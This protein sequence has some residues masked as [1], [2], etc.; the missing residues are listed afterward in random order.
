[1]CYC[2]WVV[3]GRGRGCKGVQAF[4]DRKK[5]KGGE[6]GGAGRPRTGEAPNWGCNAWAPLFSVL[7]AVSGGRVH[8]KEESPWSHYGK[9]DK[10]KRCPLEQKTTSVQGKSHTRHPEPMTESCTTG[11]SRAADGR[12]CGQRWGGREGEFLSNAT[13]TGRGVSVRNRKD[14]LLLEARINSRTFLCN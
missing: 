11:L 2:Y 4:S 6:D 8:R 3:V 14:G 12:G 7:R 5:K 13:G 9:D 1:M 10:H